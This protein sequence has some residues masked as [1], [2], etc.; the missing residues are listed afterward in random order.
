MGLQ[1][2]E[3]RTETERQLL[4]IELREALIDE[5]SELIEDKIKETVGPAVAHRLGEILD[6]PLTVRQTARLTGR[7]VETVYKM[8][9]RNQLPHTKV[10][11]HIHIN[12]K[13]IS[14]QLLSLNDSNLLCS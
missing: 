13:D 7:S 12:L 4:F 5:L 11:S 2:G 3:T 9:Q 14:K 10:G 6:F 8:C 1:K